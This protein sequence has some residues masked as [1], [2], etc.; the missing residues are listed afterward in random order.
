MR[1]LTLGLLTLALLASP[2]AASASGLHLELSVGSG[3]RAGLG[4]TERIPTNVGAAVGYGFTDMLKL[5]LGAFA[6]LGDV[7][8]SVSDQGASKFDMDL[9][10]MVV[11]SPPVLPFY[12][13]GIA[14]ISDLV[15]GKKK[16]TYGGALGLGFGMF[17]VGAFVEAGAMQR[18][19]TIAVPAGTASKDGWQVEARVGASIG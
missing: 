10:A 4:N 6:A 9:R 1:K 17:G 12:V 15:D 18:T 14:G 19:Y 8:Q 16:V 11:L 2:A 5:Q 7:K 3:L 13:R